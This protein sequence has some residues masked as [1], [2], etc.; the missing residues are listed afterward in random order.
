MNA[1]PTA[2]AN[3]GGAGSSSSAGGREPRPDQRPEQ[4][5]VRGV[6]DAGLGA[7]REQHRLDAGS[8]A[9]HGLGQ[10]QDDDQHDGGDRR[11]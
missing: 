4:P 3:R 10:Q 6:L 1:R 11:R 7:D 5:G 8:T 9:A 2:C